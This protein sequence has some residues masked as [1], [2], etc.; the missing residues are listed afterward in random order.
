V[1]D[2]GAFLEFWCWSSIPFPASSSAKSASCSQ[3]VCADLS[4]RRVLV[5]GAW[6]VLR[7][8]R[9]ASG[10]FVPCPSLRRGK[11]GSVLAAEDLGVVRRATLVHELVLSAVCASVVEFGG[12]Q[13]VEE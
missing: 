2:G 9:P 12:R 13:E 1:G 4:I 3:C 8:Q 7:R 10:A 5:L 11:E 6:S